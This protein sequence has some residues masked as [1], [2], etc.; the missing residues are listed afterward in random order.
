M[1]CQAILEGG[2]QSLNGSRHAELF[3]HQMMP[4]MV[5]DNG[6]D[7]SVASKTS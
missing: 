3:G 6:S 1:W 7:G 5:C 4:V 2:S